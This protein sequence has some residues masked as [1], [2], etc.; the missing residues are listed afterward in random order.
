MIIKIKKGIETELFDVSKKLPISDLKTMI[1][2][3]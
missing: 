1:E 2:E 3:K